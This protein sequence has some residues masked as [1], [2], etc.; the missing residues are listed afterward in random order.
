MKTL[1]IL[2]II[3]GFFRFQEIIVIMFVF[4]YIDVGLT[5]GPTSHR[6]MSYFHLNTHEAS[7]HKSWN[8][9]TN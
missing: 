6:D 7:L 1:I 8:V 5:S 4:S 3:G 9:C 2:D